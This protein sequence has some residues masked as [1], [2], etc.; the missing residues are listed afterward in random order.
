M[1]ISDLKPCAGCG[2]PLIKPPHATWYVITCTQAMINAAAARQ[3]NGLSMIWG[4]PVAKVLRIAESFAPDGDD[5]V[6][7]FGEKE[8]KLLDKIHVCFDCFIDKP[9]AIILERYHQLQSDEEQEKF[10]AEEAA[11]N[12]EAAA[13]PAT[14][15][16]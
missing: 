5:G 12:P 7:I 11:K 1:K 6:L 14:E 4:Q 3:I 8:P 9:L 16:P 15:A 2:G 10:E 13:P